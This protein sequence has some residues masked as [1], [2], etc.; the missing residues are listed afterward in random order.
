M[1]M[2]LIAAVLPLTQNAVSVPL[3]LAA[4]AGFVGAV[5]FL[6]VPL[7]KPWPTA[8][9][10]LCLSGFLCVYGLSGDAALGFFAAG[11]FA[12]LHPPRRV[13]L[14]MLVVATLALNIVQIVTGSETPLTLLATDAGIAFFAAIGWLLV[15]EREQRTRADALVTELEAARRSER[16]SAVL[17]ER[18]RVAREVHDVLAHTLSGLTI[19]LEAARIVATDA[20]AHVRE[21]IDAAQRLARAGLQ[22]ARS[23]VGALRGEAMPIADIGKL[24]EEHRLATGT[25]VAFSSTG[26]ELSLPPEAALA[27]YRIVQE[28]LSNVRKHAP[29]AAATVAVQWTPTLLRISVTNPADPV[30]SPAGW[31]ITGMRER[32]EQVGARLETGWTS[33]EF[34]VRLEYP[35]RDAGEPASRRPGPV[36]WAARGE[37]SARR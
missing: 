4:V 33:G 17:A 19:Q 36:A 25:P 2:A 24:V 11:S 28:S 8:A 20:P 31:G 7:R 3:V 22:E 9:Y 5:G 12:V 23:A 35:I 1:G 16:E 18:A 13:H 10:G 6:V 32:A 29:H 27:I 34:A 26:D 21:G 37:E 30:V 14:A 15:S